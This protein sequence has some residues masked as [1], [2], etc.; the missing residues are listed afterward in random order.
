MFAS[1]RK[2]QRRGLRRGASEV[3]ILACRRQRARIAFCAARDR[4]ERACVASGWTGELAA[5]TSAGAGLYSA[6]GGAGWGHRPRFGGKAGCRSF[7]FASGRGSIKS[8]RDKNGRGRSFC[9]SGGSRRKIYG[10]DREIGIARRDR[11]FHKSGSGGK[12]TL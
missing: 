12:E 3:E 1:P 8:C 6:A 7:C 11:E 9:I 10:E 4:R 2:A 5:V